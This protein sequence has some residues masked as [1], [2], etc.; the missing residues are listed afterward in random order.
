MWLMHVCCG[1]LIE[2]QKDV[3]GRVEPRSLNTCTLFDSWNFLLLLKVV[4]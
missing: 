2:C 3:S 1:G 4:N